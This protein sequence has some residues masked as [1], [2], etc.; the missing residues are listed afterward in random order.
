LQIQ[1]ITDAL[2]RT[3]KPP[4]T[5]RRELYDSKV[6][7]LVVRVTQ[8]GKISYSFRKSVNGRHS[9]VTVGAWPMGIAE[10]RDRA[11]AALVDMQRGADPVAEKQA[12]RVAQAEAPTT[13][14]PTVR[15]RLDE[16]QTLRDSTWSA[17]HATEVARIVRHDIVPTLGGRALTAVTRADWIKL[18]TDKQVTASAMAALLYRVISAFTN[19][20]EAAGWIQQSPLPRRGSVLLAPTPRARERVLDDT[21]L[22]RV[23]H[24]A[25]HLGVRGCALTRLLILTGA[26][27]GEVA[28]IRQAEIDTQERIW[29]LPGTRAKNGKS[30]VI[31]L[32][33]LALSE[34][35]ACQHRPI[36]GAFSK[37]KS[38][39][40]TASGVTGWVL[41]DLRRTCR[42]GL[43][44]LGI[45]REVAEAAVNHARPGL[46][47]VYDRH[48]FAAEVLAALR[49]WQAHVAGLVA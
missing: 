9:R 1:T 4:A 8:T 36:T 40:D 44:R 20:A 3:V 34:L 27:L 33:P 46:V 48:D 28:G 47:G 43:S 17:R 19:Y 21:E 15:Q 7:G 32:C 16:W 5:G 6:P 42:T 2:L 23:W 12:A 41:H 22:T 13:S 30:Y 49:Q 38:R 45:P 39:L 18:V 14:L 35:S 11:R 25:G 10:A 24:A 31:P 37:L 26:R 29:K